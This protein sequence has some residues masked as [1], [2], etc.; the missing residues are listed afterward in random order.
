MFRDCAKQQAGCLAQLA[1]IAKYPARDARELHLEEQWK[2]G[3]QDG[4]STVPVSH[5]MGA[6]RETP[7]T[8]CV[9]SYRG[10]AGNS[11]KA[12]LKGE[13]PPFASFPT[14]PSGTGPGGDRD[15]A[16]GARSSPGTD[17]IPSCTAGCCCCP[18]GE[19]RSQ[20]EQPEQVFVPVNSPGRLHD[21]CMKGNLR[22]G[23]AV[24]GIR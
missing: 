23:A 17:Q 4:S 9:S 2:R 24:A 6:A 13:N 22:R 8:C 14:Q 3:D 16:H 5:A 1:Q 12:I 7:A 19:K 11:P 10:K 20:E 21:A 15:A 18:S